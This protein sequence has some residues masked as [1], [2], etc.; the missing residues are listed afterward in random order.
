[1]KAS[2]NKRNILYLL[3]FV[4]FIHSCNK[5]K[6]TQ[7]LVYYLTNDSIQVWDT[8]TFDK[9]QKISYSFDKS[10]RCEFYGLGIDGVRRIYPYDSIPDDYGLCSRWELIND[11][12]LNIMCNSEYRI[13]SYQDDS[14]KLKKLNNPGK[15]RIRVLYKVKDNWNIDKERYTTSIS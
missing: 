2:I 6:N 10:G 15:N 8:Y 9:N 1:M 3:F 14:I 11:S 7:D 4:F 5:K 12:T 13:L